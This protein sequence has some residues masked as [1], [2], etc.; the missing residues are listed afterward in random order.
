M[1]QFRNCAEYELVN[2]RNGEVTGRLNAKEVFD[3]IVESAWATGDPGLVFID[4]INEGNPNPQLGRIESTT[5][6][7]EE[8]LLPHESCNLGSLNLARMLR[9]SEAGAELDWSRMTRVI[10][11]GVRMLDNVIDMNQYP[12]PE[13]REMS[14]LTRRIGLGVMGWADLLIQLGVRYDSDQALELANTVMQFI[15]EQTHRAS[16]QLAKERGSFP[17]WEGSFYNVLIRNSA[18]VTIAPT[19]TIGIIAGASSGIEPLFALSSV[20]NV[21]DQTKLVEV[22]PYFEAAARSEGFHS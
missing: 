21:M 18:P 9:Y 7:G 22:N 3:E 10:R 8:P 6:C 1:E 15:H 19:G 17:A 16:E 20:R 5:P 4:R 14:Q 13:I 11:T 2:P 12:F